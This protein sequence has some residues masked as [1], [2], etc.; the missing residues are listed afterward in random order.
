[1]NSSLGTDKL[2]QRIG[3]GKFVEQKIP[4][5]SSDQKSAKSVS[6]I[7]AFFSFFAS[8]NL[9]KRWYEAGQLISFFSAVMI[10]ALSQTGTTSMARAIPI[11]IALAFVISVLIWACLKLLNKGFHHANKK[12]RL[13]FGKKRNSEDQAV[14]SSLVRDDKYELLETAK[15]LSYF[16]LYD[17]VLLHLPLGIAI[18]AYLLAGFVAAFLMYFSTLFAVSSDRLRERFFNK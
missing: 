2:T 18:A 15:P 5:S 4:A 3:K 16:R 9:P 7:R 13:Q 8:N 11:G 10:L 1:M 12:I 14:T 6:S 17:L